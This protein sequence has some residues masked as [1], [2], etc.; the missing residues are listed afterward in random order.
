ARTHVREARPRGAIPAARSGEIDPKHAQIM[1]AFLAA[2]QS[3]DLEAMKRLLAHDV[4]IVTDGGGK[5]RAATK[6]V[7]G[8][9]HAVRLIVEATR[10]R[11]DS[12]WRPEFTIRFATVNGQPGMIVEAPEGPVQTTAF[13]IAGDV[14][15]ALYVVR[16]PEKLRHLASTMPPP[17]HV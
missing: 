1:G 12:W 16:N 7:E 10:K 5:V 9:D 3:G 6:V 15:K 2:T 13:E 17:P 4:R 8:A 14:I 11:P